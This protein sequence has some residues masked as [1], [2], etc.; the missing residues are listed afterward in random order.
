MALQSK[1]VTMGRTGT[2]MGRCRTP[3]LT[4]TPVMTAPG[5]ANISSHVGALSFSITM[6]FFLLGYGLYPVCNALV[7]YGMVAS[8]G[9]GARLM[10]VS[11]LWWRIFECVP[12]AFVCLNSKCVWYAFSKFAYGTHF[13]GTRTI[14]IPIAQFNFIRKYDLSIAQIMVWWK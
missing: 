1:W 14:R 9:A 4:L 3:N 7:K 10:I 8:L 6:A 13:F 2:V 11:C 5:G 12:Y